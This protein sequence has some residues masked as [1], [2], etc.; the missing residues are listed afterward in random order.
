MHP[1]LPDVAEYADIDAAG[2]IEI[3]QVEKVGHGREAFFVPAIAVPV[4]NKDAFVMP[5]DHLS[6]MIEVLRRTTRILTIGWRGSELRFQEAAR[7]HL[8]S[9]TLP[10]MIVTKGHDRSAA[11]ETISN[12]AP[13]LNRSA[14]EVH[15]D[16]FT[17]FC[18]TDALRSFLTSARL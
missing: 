12:L 17:D 3:F 4:T 11:N 14:T 15:F 13:N 16:G 2:A 1:S 8:P 6:A 10:A 9:T 7:G 18:G 5:A